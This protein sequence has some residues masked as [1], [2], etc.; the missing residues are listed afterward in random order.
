M[1]RKA[2]TGPI[3]TLLTHAVD[4]DPAARARWNE[5]ERAHRQALGYYVSRAI[6]SWGRRRR[7][8][9]VLRFLRSGQSY[10]IW[11]GAARAVRGT[12]A[13]VYGTWT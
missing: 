6:T 8:A 3:P 1:G 12:D 10:E 2:R 9:Q 4:Q 11:A 7:V 13:G 5:L